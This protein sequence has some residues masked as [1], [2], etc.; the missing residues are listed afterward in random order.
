VLHHTERNS[1]G[2]GMYSYTKGAVQRALPA[3]FASLMPLLCVLL[4]EDPALL[5]QGCPDGAY[6][7]GD[8]A[9]RYDQGEERFHY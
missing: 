1:I 2:V 9:E 8:A 5:G 4:P 7:R 3:N 6:P